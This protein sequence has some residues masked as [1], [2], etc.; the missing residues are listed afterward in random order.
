MH[1]G[2]SSGRA[3]PAATESTC[4][5]R[6]QGGEE[7]REGERKGAKAPATQLHKGKRDRE[8]DGRIQGQT[9]GERKREM[10]RGLGDGEDEDWEWGAEEGAGE[11][12][13]N[14]DDKRS[15]KIKCLRPDH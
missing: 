3:K 11:G 12:E 15:E 1:L 9:E 2:S 6:T 7:G 8:K 13:E 14:S 10:E 5:T 4:D